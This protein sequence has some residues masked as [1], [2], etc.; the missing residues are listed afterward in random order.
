MKEK[1]SR[2]KP[3]N[4]VL[5]VLVKDKT[6][7]LIAQTEGWYRIPTD[8]RTPANLRENE[9]E[10]ISFY[11][12]KKFG[13]DKYSIRFYAQIIDIQKVY[14]KSLFPNES[15][16]SKS[17]KT[18]YKISFLPLIALAKPIISNR[19]R[20]LLFIPTTLEKLINADELNDIFNDSP[21]EE[22]LWQKLKSEKLPA[23]RQ[24]YLKTDEKSWVCD[25]AMFCKTGKIDIECD[26]DEH[27]TSHEAVFYDKT[28]NNEIESIANWSVLR[29]TT[30]HLTEQLDDSIQKI[31]QKIDHLGGLYYAAEDQYRYVSKPDGQLRLFG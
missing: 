11:F 31:K 20:M 10:Y 8:S 29:F 28:R 26:G 17:D 23:E 27:H 15:T 13:D 6:D 14:R 30:K 4:N 19:G 2:R 21:L 3:I 5:E 22:K 9:V 18:Y 12:P 24:F 1:I 16:N 7:W 25:F